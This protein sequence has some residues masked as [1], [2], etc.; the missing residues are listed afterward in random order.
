MPALLSTHSAMDH[1][2]GH[3]GCQQK[4]TESERDARGRTVQDVPQD[5][6]RG[7]GDEGGRANGT[8]PQRTRPRVLM[9]TCVQCLELDVPCPR[10]HLIPLER[11]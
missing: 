5:Q 4:Q 1:D 10:G 9:R 6:S 11:C 2:F 3:E 8:Q 7:D